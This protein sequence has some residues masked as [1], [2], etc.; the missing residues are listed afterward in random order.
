MAIKA[1]R[2]TEVYNSDTDTFIGKAGIV[3][4]DTSI[5]LSRKQKSFLSLAAK[6]AESGNMSYKHGAVIVKGGRVVSVG[7]NKWR[8]SPEMASKEK[9]YNPNMTYHAEADAISRVSGDLSGAVIFVA[10]INKKGLWS[11]SRPCNRCMKL[12]NSAGIKKIIYT[13]GRENYE[14][15]N[16]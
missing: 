9:E 7:I 4:L 1:T 12:I 11:F 16:R 8:I 15:S 5:E 3:N 6:V 10:R 14:L 2:I 13:T